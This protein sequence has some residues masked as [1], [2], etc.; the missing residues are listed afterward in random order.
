[1]KLPYEPVCLSVRR[2]VGRSVCGFQYSR[3]RIF[4]RL[5]FHPVGKPYARHTSKIFFFMRDEFRGCDVERLLVVDVEGEG[6]G[7]GIGLSI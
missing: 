6:G 3:F 2:T 5:K 4:P 1:M 7:G